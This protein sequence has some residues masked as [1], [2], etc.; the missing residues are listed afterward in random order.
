MKKS[1]RITV[2]VN[3]RP[4]SFLRNVANQ[5][6]CKLTIDDEEHFNSGFLN[7]VNMVTIWF[8][9]EGEHSDKC[10]NQLARQFNSW[11]ED[12]WE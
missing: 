3:A 12:C 5:Y 7:L 1:A 10:Y 11:K 2:P 4:K 8:T 6:D 9:L